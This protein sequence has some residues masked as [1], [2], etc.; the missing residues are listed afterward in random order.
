M[1]LW[2]SD[3]KMLYVT[4]QVVKWL[5]A[6]HEAGEPSFFMQPCILIQT[7]IQFDI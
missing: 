5:H 2:D 1:N 7:I 4:I 6:G 3:V